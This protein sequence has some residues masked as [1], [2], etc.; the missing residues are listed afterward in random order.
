MMSW[1]YDVGKQM[2]QLFVAPVCFNIVGFR[3]HT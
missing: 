2:S 3:T 1:G